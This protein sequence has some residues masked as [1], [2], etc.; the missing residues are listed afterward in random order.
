MRRRRSWLVTAVLSAVCLAAGVTP[1]NGQYFGQNKV[2]YHNL[3]FHVLSTNHF[4]IYFYTREQ[5]GAEI[6]ARLAERWYTRLSKLF[7]HDLRGRQPLILYASPADFRQTNLLGDIGEATGGV[8]ESIRRRII[9]PLGGSLEDTNHVLGHELVHAFQFDVTAE[10]DAPP[11]Q[12]GAQQLP[13]WFIEGMA[14]YFSLGPVD[15][16]TAMWLRDA[17]SHDKLP[18][19]KDLNDPKYFPYRWGQALWAY[20]GGRWGDQIIP[21]LL[22][23]AAI[24][25]DIDAAFKKLLEMDT[26]QL[27]TAWQESIRDTYRATIAATTRP[28]EIGKVAVAGKGLGA[29]MNIG[30]ALSPDGS[31]IAF[32]SQRSFFSTDLFIADAASGQTVRRLTSTAT[33]P[34]FSSIES[35]DS[36]GAW[37]AT[38]KRIAIAAMTGGMPALAIFD[39]DSGNKLQ[40][41]DLPGIDQV[42]NPSWSPDGRQLAFTGLK[43]GLTDL[44]T[45]NLDTKALKQLTNDP[46]ADL[47]PAWS[48]DGHEVAFATDRFTTN[49]DT[50]DLGR[51]EIGIV[52]LNDGQ[53]RRVT[54]ASS[55]GSTINPQWSPDG[56]S[57]YVIS[58]GTGIPN[59]YRLDPE[60]GAMTA[61][62]NITTGVSGITA[63]SPALSVS[64]KTGVAAFSVYD[65][66]NYNIYTLDLA[67][68]APAQITDETTGG[69]L[70][71]LK[72]QPSLVAQMLGDA[73]FGLPPEETYPVKPYHAGLSLEG[74]GQPVI[75][76]GAD[77]FGATVGGGIA[78]QFADMLNDHQLLTA[79]QYNQA[80]SGSLSGNDLSAQVAYLNQAR[81]L[82]WG[83][84]G[85]Q[86]PYLSGGYSVG[87][88]QT[89]AG[90][91]IEVDQATIYRQTERSAAGL[92]AYPFD[93]ARRVEF[94]AGVSQISFEQILDTTAYSLITGGLVS[95]TNVTSSAA[96]SLTLGTSSAAY[97]FDTT[98]FGPTSPVEGQRYRIEAAPT[99][100]SLNFTSITAD[101]RRY[102]MPISFYTIAA[103][104]MHYGR[105]G[106]GGEDSRLYPLYIGYPELV[107][108]YD[109]NSFTAAD[110]GNATNGTCPAFD[111]LLGSRMLIGNLEFRFPLL[112]P[113]RAAASARM[114]GPLPVEVALF[115]DGGVA[116]NSNQSPSI[117]G[118]SRKAVTSAG[119]AFRVSLFGYA[120]GEFSFAHPFQRP[121]RNWLFQFSL[122]PGF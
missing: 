6:T 4:D 72:R 111:N 37:D 92:V 21:K 26:K 34:H 43:Q 103:R 14:E 90:E 5:A 73:T 108:G 109:V 118:G 115:A 55:S 86:V 29:D 52:D 15:P 93:R 23:N 7:D 31:Q 59:L 19:I 51:Y 25:G 82:N 116:W 57:L 27:S 69:D 49:L 117:F 107:R 89:S 61:L 120:V 28:S 96:P 112:R 99:F 78:L 47:Q 56:R 44:Y 80:I 70:P 8:T 38:G 60:S 94:Q 101:Y 17:A 62:T 48:P 39:A 10:P 79:V 76:A 68:R 97:V 18:S 36:S 74:V 66:G 114:Y 13:L 77:R 30:P 11:G 9:M 98:N 110:C 87:L 104:I 50:L 35:L 40:E 67:T 84:V 102:F 64:A 2:Q 22:V 65:D 105:Y 3:D 1:A 12:N 20:V 58:N 95:H 53:I 42:L 54:A 100:G 88:S 71:P 16:N 24:D 41:I 106:S 33:D 81:R 83:V 121:S 122:S 32:L 85:G 46:Y 91:P 75:A 63:T 119:I 113:F 45:Y